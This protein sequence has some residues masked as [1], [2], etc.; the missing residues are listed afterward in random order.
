MA[1]RC[2]CFVLLWRTSTYVQA[3][4]YIYCF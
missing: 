3:L 2:C 1:W 4:L